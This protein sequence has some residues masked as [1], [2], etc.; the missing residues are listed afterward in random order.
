VKGA[1]VKSKTE[2]KAKPESKVL[3]EEQTYTTTKKRWPIMWKA[4]EHVTEGKRSVEVKKSIFLELY[5]DVE[6]YPSR[7]VKAM[8]KDPVLTKGRSPKE[9]NEEALVQELH[10]FMEAYVEKTRHVN[11]M[12]FNR[13]PRPVSQVELEEELQDAYGTIRSQES[14]NQQQAE[15]IENLRKRLAVYEKKEGKA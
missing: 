1:A 11:V 12:H 13:R 15:E 8:L 3:R 4:G 6:F 7:F 9:L 10:E 2:S 14:V 5:R